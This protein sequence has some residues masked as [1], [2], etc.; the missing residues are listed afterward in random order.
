MAKQKTP[1][2][3]S[4]SDDALEKIKSRVSSGIVLEDDKAIILSILATHQWL[5]KQLRS[6]KLSINRLKNLFG[7][8]TEKRPCPKTPEVNSTMPQE[9]GEIFNDAQNM[10]TIP[11]KKP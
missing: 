7:F 3:I 2:I 5:Y 4:L 9:T 10:A 6:A 8:S 11:P 1:E